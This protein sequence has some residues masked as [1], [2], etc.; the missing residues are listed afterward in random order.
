M[1]NIEPAYGTYAL[2]EWRQRLLN[3][4]QAFPVTWLGRRA[5][6][7]ARRFA[8]SGWRGPIDGEAEGFRLRVHIADNVSERKFLFMPQFVDP[9]ER[10]F[11]RER[12][13]EQG[14]LFLDIGANAGIYSLTAAGALV[15]SG[16]PGGVIC[17]EPNPTMLAR[18]H[19][20]L[21]LN[22]YTQIVRVLPIALSEG[23]G[24]IEFTISA[25]NLGES[26]LASG[27]GSKIRVPCD[28]LLNV[29]NKAGATK[30]AGMKIDVEGLEDRILMPFL[31]DASPSLYPG[32]II[33]ESSQ[34]VW[35][36]DLLGEL[37]RRGYKLRQRCKMN[38]IYVF[39]PEPLQARSA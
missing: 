18:L 32:F 21:A 38:A 25:T 6:L 9:V 24:E 1:N 5:A 35:T 37:G 33:I 28:S 11:I 23:P 10:A 36:E 39:T 22:A 27:E 17:V 2:P 13:Q 8:L 34:Q 20:N 29:L 15:G 3:L 31:R 12:L 26:G 14:G 19:T 16:K 4:A 30:V 7:I